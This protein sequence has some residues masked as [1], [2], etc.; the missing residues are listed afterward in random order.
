MA[1]LLRILADWLIFF[2]DDNRY[3]LVYSEVGSTYGDA[4]VELTSDRIRWRLVR[5]RSQVRLICQ[6]VEGTYKKWDW[7][8][9]DLL[10]RLITGSP[11]NSAMLTP[12]VAQW[13][14]VHLTEIEERFANNRL[15]ETIRELRHMERVRA[16]EIF[17]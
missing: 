6:P 5:D 2:F 1:E 14:S 15:P 17:E 13:L 12:E 3:R 4:L 8:S 16:K 10:M 7:F 9:I 11:P